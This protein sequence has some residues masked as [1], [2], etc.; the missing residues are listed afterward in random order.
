[1]NEILVLKKDTNNKVTDDKIKR[2][3][4]C[5]RSGP[6]VCSYLSLLI[7]IV[8]LIIIKILTIGKSG[9]DPDTFP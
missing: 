1:M 8:L 5:L 2:M 6:M 4:R 9:T 7:I 3:S